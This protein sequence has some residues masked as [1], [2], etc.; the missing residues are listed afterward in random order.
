M[1]DPHRKRLV[2]GF[3]LLSGMGMWLLVARGN[4]DA[5][6]QTPSSFSIQ[7]LEG[8]QEQTNRAI[9]PAVIT[10]GGKIIW[11]AGQSGGG[12]PGNFAGQA[13]SVFDRMQMT[14]ARSNASLK[15]VVF[16]KVFIKAD[17]ANS[18]DLVKILKEVFPDGKYPASSVVT[19]AYAA[20]LIEIQGVAVVPE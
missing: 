20:S 11:L 13:R 19:V 5:I 1:R 4:A 10:Q 14:L 2:A 16:L 3:L 15:N 17:P 6:P 7:Y 12:S 8:T 18:D 9:S